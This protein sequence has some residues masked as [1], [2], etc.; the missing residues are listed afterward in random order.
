MKNKKILF[1]DILFCIVLVVECISLFL[2]KSHYYEAA[3]LLTS[4]IL[5]IYNYKGEKANI[6]SLYI[7]TGISIIFIADI[8]TLFCGGFLFFAGLS[9]FT[10][11]YIA[12]AAIFY[13][14]RQIVDRKKL[15]ITLLGWA[16]VQFVLIGLF[17]F[18]AGIADNVWIAQGILHT[19]V[20]FILMTWAIKANKRDGINRYFLIAAILM[21]LANIC[22]ALVIVQNNQYVMMRILV[23][24]LHAISLLVLSKATNKYLEN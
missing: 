13:R 5:F 6:F 19:I 1:L 12:F 4:V 11:S 3:R 21:L 22:Y 8:L 9:M 17:Y 10:L 20:L 18:V 7:Y 24:S 16:I 2:L 23:I 15:P 14:C